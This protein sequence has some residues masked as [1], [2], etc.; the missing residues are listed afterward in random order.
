VKKSAVYKPVVKKSMHMHHSSSSSLSSD[1]I[2]SPIPNQDCTDLGGAGIMEYSDK[3][4][5][6]K[7]FS[8]PWKDQIENIKQA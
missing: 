1:E 2:E 3:L 6:A 8:K 4:M 7:K 5:E